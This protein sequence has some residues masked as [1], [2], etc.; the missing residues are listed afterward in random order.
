MSIGFTFT[1]KGF[2]TELELD[3]NGNKT[4]WVPKPAVSTLTQADLDTITRLIKQVIRAEL[5]QGGILLT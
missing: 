1:N 2:D 4:T 3:I 5:R